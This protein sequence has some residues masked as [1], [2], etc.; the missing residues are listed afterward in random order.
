MEPKVLILD[1]PTAGLDPQMSQEVMELVDQMCLT[2]TTVII[3]THDVDLAYAW[4]DEIH[5]LRLGHLVYSGRPEDFFAQR[6]AVALSG[7]SLPHTFSVNHSLE[8]IRGLPDEPYPRTNS[9]LLAKLSPP[10]A[11]FGRIR[12]VPIPSDGNIDPGDAVVGVYGFKAKKLFRDLGRRADIN[13][14][15][16]EGCCLSAM[17]GHDSVIYCDPEL[18]AT[19]RYRVGALTR[20]GRVPEVV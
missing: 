10:D 7:L 4:A 19:I 15:A 14:N 16:I 8:G 18:A 17:Q 13:F 1:E 2:G 20:F 11:E 9:Q 12:I 3:S 6:D 5:V